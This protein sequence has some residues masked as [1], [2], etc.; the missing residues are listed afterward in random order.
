MG[1]T[2][3]EDHLAIAERHVLEGEQY[4]IRHRTLVTK[5]EQGRNPAATSEAQTLLA[6][7]QQMQAVYIADRDWL[8]AEFSALSGGCEQR[9][10]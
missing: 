10:L 1:R 9:K 2:M 5:L 4:L 6:Q 7:F 8:R 3:V